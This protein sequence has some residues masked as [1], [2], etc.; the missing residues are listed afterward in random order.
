MSEAST[1]VIG[2]VPTR[3]R[4]ESIDTLRGFALL[5]ILVMNIT[6]TAFPMAAYFN[7]TVYGGMDPLNFGAWV[8][9]HLL[10]DMKFMG[11]FSMLFGAGL[12]LMWQR[13]EAAGKPFGRIHY[14]RT[15]W[16]LII[17]LIHAYVIWHGDILVTYALCGLLLYLFRR[18]R[19]VTL[20]ICSA[21]FL[22]FGALLSVGGG[23]AQGQLRNVATEI[24]AKVAA[25]EEMTLRRQNLVDQWDGLRREFMP[26]PAEVDE[27]IAKYRGAPATVLKENVNETIGMHL[28]A[29]PFF[30]FWRGMGMML[31]GMALMK[32]GMFSA[33]RSSRSYR[34]WLA[35]GI[36][37]GLPIVAFGIWRWSGNDFDFISSFLVDG[38]FNYFG[39]VLVSL[40]WVSGVM[41]VCRSGALT[42]FRSRLAAV[43]RMALTNYVMQSVIMVLIFWGYGLALF[44]S[45][46]RFHLWWFIL[47]IWAFQLVVSPW[48]LKR[49]RFGPLEW[50]WRTLTYWQAQPMRRHA[51]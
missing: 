45:F 34:T 10:F 15:F 47:G 21:L 27:K 19:P 30:L 7:P 39:S 44:G 11:I 49:F 25:G 38:Q 46:S 5:G 20:I 29:V 31:L 37:V 12:I 24:E 41:L 48:W 3:K 2:P 17:G 50:L 13:A 1:R 28:Q 18:R 16:L 22:I 43:G 26:T 6:G 51:D 35:I 8:F 40:G 23:F 9:S 36:L 42:G 4:I 33:E 32:L 14:R